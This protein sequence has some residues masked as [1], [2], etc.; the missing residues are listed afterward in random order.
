MNSPCKECI[1]VPICRN[2]SFQQ[3]IRDCTMSWKFLYIEINIGAEITTSKVRRINFDVIIR[4]VLKDLKPT[5]WEWTCRPHPGYIQDLQKAT[6]NHEK[7][8]KIIRV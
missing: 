7:W 4:Q 3:L 6:D 2:K 5:N 8:Y 1:C